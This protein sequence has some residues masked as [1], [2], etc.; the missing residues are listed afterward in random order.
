AS[1]RDEAHKGYASPEGYQGTRRCCNRA[2]WRGLN[3]RF[4][5]PFV[6]D[7]SMPGLRS[8]DR[9]SFEGTTTSSG[10]TIKFFS[11]LRPSA[12]W[13][14]RALKPVALAMM[15]LALPVLTTASHAV[16]AT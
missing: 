1:K 16:P 12:R 15:L 10:A 3:R 7:A 5:R 4:T 14:L 6:A 11:M 9:F 2:T 13:S 8:H